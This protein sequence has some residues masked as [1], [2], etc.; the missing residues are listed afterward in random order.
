MIL[1]YHLVQYCFVHVLFCPYHFVYIILS[2][3]FCL[4]HFV[5]TILFTSF[6]PLPFCLHHFVHTILFTSFC[7]HHFVYII[8]STTI[9]F[10]SFCPLPFCHRS[11]LTCNACS[12]SE[13]VSFR[14]MDY[15]LSAPVDAW[16]LDSIEM[17]T[18]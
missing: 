6:C 9:L 3:P 11:N 8:L 5:H 12:S 1:S 15:F 16:S 17:P 13:T 14:E 18:M 7:P 4:H 2:I 10:T